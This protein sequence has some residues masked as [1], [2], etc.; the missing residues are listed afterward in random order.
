MGH[1]HSFFKF[2]LMNKPETYIIKYG[3]YF[4]DQ[5]YQSGT[6]KVKNCFS[7]LQAKIKLEKY[8]A[9]KHPMFDRMVVYSCNKDVLGFFDFFK[10]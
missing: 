3:M 8:L 6:M 7:D 5:S 2:Y 10:K 4:T 9:R 1:S